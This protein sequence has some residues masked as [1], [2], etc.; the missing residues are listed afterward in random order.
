MTFIYENQK[1]VKYVLKKLNDRLVRVKSN[2]CIGNLSKGKCSIWLLFSGQWYVVHLTAIRYCTLLV[3]GH[4][5][6]HTEDEVDA[7]FHCVI[8]QLKEVLL[9]LNEVRRKLFYVLSYIINIHI[10]VMTHHWPIIQTSKACTNTEM[11][12]AVQQEEFVLQ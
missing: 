11:L 7:R 9:A 1:D 4:V 12:Y 5:V 8:S 6:L 10:L 2:L 3:D